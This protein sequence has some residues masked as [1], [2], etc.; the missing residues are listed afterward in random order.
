[1]NLRPVFACQFLH[2]LEFNNDV[3]EAD[4]VWFVGLRQLDSLVMQNQFPLGYKWNALSGEFS[5]QSFLVEDGFQKPA[6]HFAVNLEYGSPYSVALLFKFKVCHFRVFCGEIA[7]DLL[8]R[9]PQPGEAA[10]GLYGP[11]LDLHRRLKQAFLLQEKQEGASTNLAAVVWNE[12][13]GAG[14]FVILEQ[15]YAGF[16]R[17]VER[18][19]VH[20]FLN[21]QFA[22]IGFACCRGTCRKRLLV[23]LEGAG[24][25]YLYLITFNPSGQFLAGRCLVACDFVQHHIDQHNR[26]A[27]FG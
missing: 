27:R 16:L 8:R 26:P 12:K 17:L 21:R 25:A 5:F 10:S 22:E 2:C 9:K 23:M 19:V 1:M 4:E 14:D 11:P 20:G 13:A 6:A 15:E 24:R 18:K 7:G 3:L